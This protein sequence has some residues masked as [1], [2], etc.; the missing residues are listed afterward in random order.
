[1]KISIATAKSRHI[2]RGWQ[3]ETLEWSELAERLSVPTVTSETMAE[4]SAMPRDRKVDCKDVGG[5][6]GGWCINGMRRVE[7]IMSRDLLT[8][9]YDDFDATRL[10][11]VKEALEGLAWCLYST[12]SHTKDSWRVRIIIPVERSINP[13]EFSAVA[14]KVAEKIGMSGLDKGSFDLNRLMFWP[15]VSKD[16]DYMFETAD[17]EFLNP[18]QILAEYSNW[19]DA[20][21]WPLAEDERKADLFNANATP[22]TAMMAFSRRGNGGRLADPTEKTGI[23]GAFCRTYD[24]PAAIARYLG[25]MYNPAPN[26]HYTHAG[27]S[28]EGNAKLVEGGKYIYSFHDTDPLSRRMLNSWDLVRLGLFRDEDETVSAD[29]R[30]ERLPSTKKM[31]ELALNDPAV[32]KRFVEEKGNDFADLDLETD[33]PSGEK[34]EPSEE[35][36]EDLF[37]LLDIVKG[38]VAVTAKNV[39]RILKLDP[40]LK[41]KLRLDVFSGNIEILGKLPWKTQGKYWRNLDKDSLLTYFDK[42]YGMRKNTQII[43]R[44]FNDYLNNHCIHPVKEYLKNLPEWD[45]K[46]RLER[47]FVD[48]LGAEDLAVNRKLAEL[49]FTAAVRRIEEPGAKFDYCVILFGPEGAYKSTLFSVMGGEWF[50][51]S[52]SSI[53]GKDGKESI[54]GVWIAEISELTGLKKSEQSTQKS[55]ISSQFDRFRPAYG[56]IT[57][58]R[59]RQCVIVG[60]TNEEHF[61]KGI[62]DRN[63]RMPVVEIDPELKKIEENP[64]EWLKKW[65]DQLWAEAKE[66]EKKKEPLYLSKDYE[67]EIKEVQ[68]RHNSDLDDPLYPAIVDYLDWWLP[69]GWEK[70]SLDERR[71]LM[72]D[73]HDPGDHFNYKHQRMQVT[74]PEILGECADMTPGHPNYKKMARTVGQFMKRIPGWKNIGSTR[75][76]HMVYKTWERII[77]ETETIN[78]FG[79]TFPDPLSIL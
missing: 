61:L 42:K 70:K 28:T 54:Q 11:K 59:P 38:E 2:K 17:G 56:T 73:P 60:T 25:H 49:I 40:K 77:T 19:R 79:Y 52:V 76:G 20:S 6:V 30:T 57:E 47:L 43:E 9:D 4:Y 36:E 15:S 21:E 1:M 26:G 23:I 22:G 34:P 69:D 16:G 71:A 27:S 58:I 14:R 5:F 44:T 78:S 8:Y 53:E 7:N 24:V 67:A 62:N 48:V 66:L 46:K 50:S 63:R 37:S 3:N 72:N 45:G 41:D 18:A 35:K 65:R 13:D 64:R 31:E 39:G 51:D 10:E 55:F 29:T 12:H 74:I 33:E 32:K 68:E 75:N